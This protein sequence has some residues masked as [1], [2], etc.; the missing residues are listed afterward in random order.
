MRVHAKQLGGP[1]AEFAHRPT[2]CLPAVRPPASS[3]ILPHQF[4]VVESE[5]ELA[6]IVLASLTLYVYRLTH[7]PEDRAA[8]S[9]G[10]WALETILTLLLEIANDTICCMWMQY[11]EKFD[12]KQT[13]LLRSHR[14]TLTAFIMIGVT[15]VARFTSP[16][17]IWQAQGIEPLVYEGE[18]YWKWS[19]G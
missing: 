5:V 14:I 10:D 9:F 13:H 6:N 17:S 4:F 11:Y 1:D 18:F 7:K 19:Y 16:Y 8:M 15:V 3:R 2:F 12:F